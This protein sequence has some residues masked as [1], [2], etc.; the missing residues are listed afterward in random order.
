MQP[1]VAHRAQ[2]DSQ[3]HQPNPC[4]PRHHRH[5]SRAVLL[6]FILRRISGYREL[7]SGRG[8]GPRGLVVIAVAADLVVEAAAFDGRL[9]SREHGWVLFASKSVTVLCGRTE[10]GTTRW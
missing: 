4:E 1:A 7:L 6:K 10:V 3:L 8:C 5:K 9:H 2:Q